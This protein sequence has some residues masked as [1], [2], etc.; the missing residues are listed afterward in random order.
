MHSGEL[1]VSG[2]FV[3]TPDVFPDDRGVFVSP[4][5][6][7]ALLD[8]VGLRSFPL[9]Q[10]S[11]SRSREGVVRGV[12]FTATPPGCAKYVHC[13]QGR[14]LDIVVDIRTGSPTFGKWDAVILDPDE[15]RAVYLPIGVG[16]AFVALTDDT[17][18][19]YLLSTAYDPALEMAISVLDPDLALPIPPASEHILSTRDSAAPA[20]VT[21]AEAG[22]LPDYESCLQLGST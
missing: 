3:F 8:T 2:A 18:M 12:H 17:I 14:A 15:A 16:H 1:L 13:P 22:L 6:Q 21:A 20:L 10:A 19:S 5:Q 9:A 4:L 7:N 11:Y